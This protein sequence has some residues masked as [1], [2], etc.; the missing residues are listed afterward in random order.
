MWAGGEGEG[1]PLVDP[2]YDPL[3]NRDGSVVLWISGGA[4][5]LLAI[6]L[7]GFWTALV[8]AVVCLVVVAAVWVSADLCGMPRDR[9]FL[10]TVRIKTELAV[11]LTVVAVG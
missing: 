6:L 1:D 11:I 8:A 5:L 3:Y 10:Y 7:I 2:L 4:A 9:N